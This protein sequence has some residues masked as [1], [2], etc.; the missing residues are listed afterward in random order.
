MPAI[1]RLLF[2]RLIAL[3]SPGGALAQVPVAP[4]DPYQ[5]RC[6]EAFA[7]TDEE[8]AR[9]A[10]DEMNRAKHRRRFDVWR[11]GSQQG[12]L[13]SLYL[14]AQRS[15][16]EEVQGMPGVMT[17]EES[18]AA[19]RTLYDYGFPL[20]GMRLAEEC[21]SKLPEVPDKWHRF[22]HAEKK[23]PEMIAWLGEVTVKREGCL[24]LMREGAF[25]GDRWGWERLASYDT[26]HPTPPAVGVVPA[27]EQY[28]WLELEKL[29]WRERGWKDEHSVPRM[30][31]DRLVDE[32]LSEGER[33]EAQKLAEKYAEVIWPRRM[34]GDGSAGVCRMKPQFAGDPD[35][36]GP[37]PSVR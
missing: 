37:D 32:L 16:L 27:V 15:R 6:I 24:D 36:Y 2:F 23:P 11:K 31:Q 28:A 10:G 29:R 5:E 30:H 19:Y 21:W 33:R 1:S 14:L 9:A 20:A 12:H 4:R 26:T 8:K 18:V 22:I 17:P 7:E 13:P 35:P 25:R 3:A 34:V